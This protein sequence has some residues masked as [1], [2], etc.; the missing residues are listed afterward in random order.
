MEHNPYR[1]LPP[2]DELVT[3]L[4]VDLPHALLVELAR[5]CLDEARRQIA[6]G[7]TPDV[8]QLLGE[9]VASEVRRRGVPVVNASGVLLH[10]NLGRAPWSETA[11]ESA[12]R[13]ARH[14]SNVELD[15]ATGTRDRRGQ[16]V[17]RLI[18]LLTGAEDALV[19]NN[20]AAALFLSLATLASGRAVPV[21]RG[22]LIEIGGSY[23]LPDV[24]AA[25]QARLVEVGTTNRVRVGDYQV[26]MQTHDCGAIL[27]IHPSNYQVV[28]FTATPS[29]SELRAGTDEIP[30]LFDVG[31]GLLD[32][33]APWVP[34]WLGGE[35]AVK[36][37][38]SDGADLVM[39]SGDKLLGGPQAGILAGSAE[40]MTRLRGSALSRAFRVDGVTYAALAATLDAYVQGNPRQIPF[41]DYALTDYDS[42]TERV[43]AIASTTGGAVEEGATAV[44]GGSA[45]G[46]EIP[47]P[48]IRY[49]G[50]QS[51]FNALLARQ[52]PILARREAGDLIVD[53]RGVPSSM[54]EMLADALRE[55]RS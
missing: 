39:F 29:I 43:S 28:G 49:A 22:E 42:L 25:S 3:G 52:D 10:T 1:Q 35:P 4:E 55:C 50:E 32:A 13:A 44:G 40:V 34:A 54:D 5:Q 46:V 11:V 53:I 38:L 48:V 30:L 47:S 23:R 8:P 17:S 20:N 37:S 16:H 36:Q 41:W 33:D 9:L 51:W 26:A 15:L 19:V 12:A 18:S 2:V 24:M 27:K 14:Y 6:R 7:A 45:P 21:A 31:S